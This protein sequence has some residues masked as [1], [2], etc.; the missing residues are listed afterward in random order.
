MKKYARYREKLLARE[1]KHQNF[2]QVYLHNGW[3]Y[4][5]QINEQTTNLHGKQFSKE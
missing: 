2:E 1:Y 3:L 4:Y 5:L